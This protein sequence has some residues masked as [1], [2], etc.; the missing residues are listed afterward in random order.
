MLARSAHSLSAPRLRRRT[1]VAVVL[2]LGVALPVCTATS[3]AGAGVPM[4]AEVIGSLDL[5]GPSPRGLRVAGWALYPGYEGPLDIHVYVDGR[6]YVVRA[7]RPRPDV[8]EALPYPGD[9]GFDTMI[10]AGAG[11]HEVCVWA[12]APVAHR[13]NALLGCEVVVTDDPRSAGSLD[14]VQSESGVMGG[15]V[16]VAGWAY[17]SRA[18]QVFADGRYVANPD[19]NEPRPDVAQALGLGF[20]SVGFDVWIVLPPGAH[21]VCAIALEASVNTDLGCR[22]VDSRRGSPFGVIDDIRGAPGGVHFRGWSIDPWAVTRIMAYV[23][24]PYFASGPLEAIDA[25]VDGV[26]QR[27]FWANVDRPDVAAA[28]SFDYRQTPRPR[29]GFDYDVAIPTGEHELCL[30]AI[31]QLSPMPD[32][33]VPSHTWLGCWSVQR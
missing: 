11:R 16:R 9:H 21:D 4:P 24:T 29:Y 30:V 14:L 31:Y 10:D 6:G 5:A 33:S 26:P 3:S 23:G 19:T 25:V 13:D 17:P 28:T 20:D 27:R 32:G 8:N 22:R 18:V 2:A 12:I 15:A 1:F 7:P